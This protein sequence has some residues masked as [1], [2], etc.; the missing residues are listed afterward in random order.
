MAKLIN[1]STNKEIAESSVFSVDEKGITTVNNDCWKR[2][3]N[4]DL[5]TEPEYE[6]GYYFDKEL[7]PQYEKSVVTPEFN[8]KINDIKTAFTERAKYF[9]G[10]KGLSFSKVTYEKASAVMSKEIDVASASYVTL[11]VAAE[12]GIGSYAEFYIVDGIKEIPILETAEKSVVKEKLFYDVNT[13]FNIDPSYPVALYEDGEL[14]D[15]SYL[16]LSYADFENHEYAL[17]YTAVG[18]CYKYTPENK[19]VRVKTIIRCAGEDFKP[20]KLQSVILNKYGSPLQWN[21]QHQP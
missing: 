14:I 10:L 15:R 9:F 1:N 18:D 13:R 8:E 2:V 16:D 11:S 20:L 5:R 21:L 4:K 7:V 3:L 19:K 6:D 17:S 12:P